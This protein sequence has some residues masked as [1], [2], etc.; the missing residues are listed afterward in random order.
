M[1]LYK[2]GKESP[3]LHPVDAAGWKLLGWAEN[4]DPEPP[5][6]KAAIV[7]DAGPPPSSVDGTTLKGSV[8]KAK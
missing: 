8:P 6:K 4:P 7:P 1:I 2:D 3:S 5:P